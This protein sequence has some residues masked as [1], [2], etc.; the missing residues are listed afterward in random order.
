[1]KEESSE[2]RRLHCSGIIFAAGI[3]G[4]AVSTARKNLQ[5][6]CSCCNRVKGNGH[7]HRLKMT[8]LR[9]QNA[10]PGV[11]VDEQLAVLTGKRLAQRHQSGTVG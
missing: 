11:M 9:V 10:R 4:T 6:L 3:V 7:S 5:L 1:M 2:G 8:E